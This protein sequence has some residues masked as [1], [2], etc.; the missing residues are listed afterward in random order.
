M[1]RTVMLL[2]I[3]LLVPSMALADNKIGIVEV[4]RILESS[5]PGKQALGQ[6]TLRFEEMRDDLEQ[7]RAEV[8]RMRQ[9]LQQQSMVLSQEAQ[10]DMEAELRQKMQQFQQK[11]Q[12]YQARMQQEEQELSDPIIDL[13]FEVIDDFA[14]KKGFDMIL[15]AQGSGIIYA[16]DAMNITDELM[17]E[18]NQAWEARN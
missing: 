7:E 16:R 14:D 13:L 15:D 10:Q 1:K 12:S 8:E 11:Y 9:E 3:C 18:V 6:L 2:I 17:E 4:Q 5:E